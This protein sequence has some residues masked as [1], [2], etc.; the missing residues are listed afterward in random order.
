M[1]I[2]LGSQLYENEDCESSLFYFEKASKFRQACY[3]FI[4][5]KNIV[6]FQNFIVILSV[7]NIAFYTYIDYEHNPTYASQYI[8]YIHYV[9]Y[10][11]YLN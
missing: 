7:I 11:S 8:T 9:G 1:I 4:K 10:F 3:K 2:T 5:A 6:I